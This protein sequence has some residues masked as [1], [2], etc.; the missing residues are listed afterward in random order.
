MCQF[1][2]EDCIETARIYY[3]DW[4]NNNKTIPNNF[5]QIVYETVIKYGNEN[6]WFELYNMS[7]RE[8]SPS[9][10]LRM[11]RSLTASRDYNLL[12]L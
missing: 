6:N 10:R 3:S 1:G 4:K 9:E 11:L 2:Y 5:K 7:M 12:R 8:Q